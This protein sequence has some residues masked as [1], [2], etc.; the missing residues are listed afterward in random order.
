[1]ITSHMR[2]LLV[3]RLP[4][5]SLALC[6][7]LWA[8]M[9]P[10][11][12]A[13]GPE[14]PS[15]QREFPPYPNVW[16]V[17]ADLLGKKIRTVYK[18]PN[19]DVMI[20]YGKHGELQFFRGTRRLPKSGEIERP[21]EGEYA[22][23]SPTLP[24]GEKVASYGTQ[25]GIYQGCYDGLD[26]YTATGPADVPYQYRVQKSVFYLLPRPRQHASP[27][28]CN[29]TRKFT[30]R[31]TTIGG[32]VVPL[33]DNGILLIDEAR[34]VVIRFD[35]DLNTR[36]R[37]LNKT[38]FVVD[39]ETYEAWRG[40]RDFGDRAGAGVDFRSMQQELRTW[41]LKGQGK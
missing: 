27:E 28:H 26:A 3:E 2:C 24:N 4:S 33:D 40:R 22:T 9:V 30:E 19:G 16:D 13:A 11:T 36:S 35:S 20:D 41:L 38:L 7:L 1:M 5:L 8:G 10:T 18:M 21:P 32:L 29:E 17:P 39:T 14:A 15:D 23:P 37:L 34:G 25:S 6:A 12:S 31:V